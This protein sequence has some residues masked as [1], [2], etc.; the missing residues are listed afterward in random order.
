MTPQD[1]QTIKQWAAQH[2][3]DPGKV[4]LASGNGAEADA[5]ARFGEQL[6]QLIPMIS[7][8]TDSDEIAFEPP[9][10]VVGP[11]QNIGFQVVPSGKILEAF[12]AAL[13]P[14]PPTNK[15]LNHR[16]AKR[17]KKIDLP[18]DLTLYIALQCPHC[19]NTLSRLIPLACENRLIRLCIID[20]QLFSDKSNKNQVKSVPTLLL[21]DRFRWSG[22]IDIDEVLAISVERDPA[23]LSP[24]SLRQLIEDGQA[25]R[26]ATMML[27]SQQIFPALIELLIHERWSVR[28][29]A[30]VTA[31]YLAAGSELLSLTLS[32]MLWQR[33]ADLTEQVRGDVVHV[34][35]ESP[36]DVN[37]ARLMKIATGA[38]GDPAKEAAEEVLSEQ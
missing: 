15:A 8:H 23:G 34:L 5:I 36:S 37:Q 27:D 12:L 17:L 14:Q 16:I 2:A 29:G 26:V 18:V 6:K 35:G 19:P 21:D 33:F 11:Q 7:I 20:A 3:V 25:E 32:D 38:F 1:K 31:E 24:G 28:L 30:M 22:K 9:T 13:P 4:V 10:V